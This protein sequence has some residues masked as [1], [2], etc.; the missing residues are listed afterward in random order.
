MDFDR[1]MKGSARDVTVGR[2]FLEGQTVRSG[3]RFDWISTVLFML[4][5]PVLNVS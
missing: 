2:M 1:R 3:M 4:F 5:C